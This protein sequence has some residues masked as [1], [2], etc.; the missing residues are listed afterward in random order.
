MDS[1]KEYIQKLI[2]I[3]EEEEKYK[4]RINTIKDEKEKINEYIINFM[5][6]NNIKDK[7]IIMGDKKINYVNSKI[8]DTITKKLILER[9]KIFLKSEEN[10]INATNFIY[11]DRNKSEKKI[12]KIIDIKK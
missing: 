2:D 1:L 9:L 5:E 6:S 7:N 3:N 12:I 4:K 10:A 11:S 8:S